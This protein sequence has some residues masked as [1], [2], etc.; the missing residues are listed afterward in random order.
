MSAKEF[1]K[2]IVDANTKVTVYLCNG[3]KLQG[4][5]LEQHDDSIILD[6]SGGATNLVFKHAISTVVKPKDG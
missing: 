3:V 1:I 2:Q 5:I 6:G 4:R